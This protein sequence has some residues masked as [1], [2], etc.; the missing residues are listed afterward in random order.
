VWCE[1]HEWIGEPEDKPI[2][3]LHIDMDNYLDGAKV[4][5]WRVARHLP[6]KDCQSS[7]RL[8]I[9][10]SLT[11]ILIAGSVRYTIT[12]SLHSYQVIRS[13]YMSTLERARAAYNLP[14]GVSISQ[15]AEM[16]EAMNF[17]GVDPS[18]APFDPKMFQKAPQNVRALRKLSRLGREHV[19]SE[20]KELAGT[21]QVVWK[22]LTEGPVRPLRRRHELSSTREM[23]ASSVEAPREAELTPTVPNSKTTT[24]GSKMPTNSDPSTPRK[25]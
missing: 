11:L 18:V 2:I 24:S 8:L 22:P 23:D 1:P 16:W 5:A 21:K 4:H 19:A 14:T 10:C 17:G 3:E 12:R 9:I 15:M 6:Q 25:D 7:L 20:A 13:S